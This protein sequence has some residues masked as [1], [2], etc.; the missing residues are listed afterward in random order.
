MLRARAYAAAVA[1]SGK[2]LVIGGED[3]HAQTAS[4]E[5]YD[6][7]LDAWSELAPMASQRAGHLATA[8]PD[9]SV[10]V[11]GG[12]GPSTLPQSAEIY[13]PESDAWS[14][15]APM[16]ERR[17]SFAWTTLPSG[18]VVVSGGYGSAGALASAE[19]YEAENDAWIMLPPMLFAR[20]EHTLSALDDG[21]VLAV[22]GGPREVEL[23]APES[24][25]APGAAS[26]GC[27]MRGRG[28]DAGALFGILLALVASRVRPA[29]A[30]T[31][32]QILRAR[33]P[34]GVTYRTRGVGSRSTGA[35]RRPRSRS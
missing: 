23:L 6:P 14:S 9:G 11:A 2:V 13:D 17:S 24:I 3:S 31:D 35:I 30:R 19:L 18:K 28:S 7:V 27:A 34:L 32:R 8:L 20:V 21:R 10:L 1:L 4:V 5:L 16:N 12:R 33:W 26:G 29:R 25:E 22:G 15:A